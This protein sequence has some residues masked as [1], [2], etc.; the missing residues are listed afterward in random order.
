MCI[1]TATYLPTTRWWSIALSPSQPGVPLGETPQLGFE[2]RDTGMIIVSCN[3]YTDLAPI[4]DL[5]VVV[6]FTS[7][8][9]VRIK[10]NTTHNVMQDSLPVNPQSTTSP[11]TM[12]LSG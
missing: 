6:S 11:D 2:L 3:H 7:L 5:F 12:E 9:I 8:K 10:S 1:L 4:C